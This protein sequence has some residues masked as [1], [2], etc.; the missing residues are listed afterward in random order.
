MKIRAKLISLVLGVVILGVA[1]VGAYI[2]LISPVDRI[3][4]DE[5]HLTALSEAI[6]DQLIELNTLP[7]ARLADGQT[8]CNEHSKIVDEAFTALSKVKDLPKL[9]RDIQSALDVIANLQALNDERLETLRKDFD[10][11]YQD[12]TAVFIFPENKRFSDFYSYSKNP[13]KKALAEA[14]VTHTGK[15]ISDLSILQDSLGASLSTIE[16]QHGLIA[17]A[18]KGIKIVALRTALAIV[19][20]IMILTVAL[21]L[22]F[23]N[24]IAGSII[25]MERNIGKLKEGDISGR[26]VVES[27]DEIGALAGNLNLFLDGLAESLHRIKEISRTNI[28]VKNKLAEEVTEATSST[29]QIDSN[30]K[31]I[32]AQI[33]TLDTRV[34]QSAGSIGKIVESIEG[35]NEQIEGQS[36]MVEEATASVTEMLASLENMSRVTEKDREST[37]ELV[38]VLER[39]RSV[40]DTAFAKVGEIP[41]SIGTI[42]DMAAVIHNIASQ[43]NLLAM[44]AAIEAAHAG[45]AGRGF[46]VVADEI[47][48]LSEL[49]TS[50][51]KDIADSIK[52][53]V[54]KIDEVT[55]ANKGTSQAFS[56]IDVKIREVAKSTSEL[57]ASISEIQT[58]SKQ[59]LQAMVDLQERSTHVKEGSKA[60]D[61]GSTDIRKMTEELT[62]IS[63]EVGSSIAEIVAGV[64]EIGRA[65]R[66]VAEYDD[67]VGE[68]SGRLDSEISRF[69]T[70]A[71]EA[72]TP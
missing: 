24:S 22:V 43:T 14:A 38:Q 39:G 4:A 46:A 28:E 19:L 17:T 33:K 10:V 11:I 42:R 47:R 6:K 2:V 16:E 15:F 23:A 56:A 35:L 61:E 37:D 49:S 29:S 18:L 57:Y 60:M 54:T 67:R 9:N 55:E 70:R 40:F 66:S 59:I 31:S 41:Q 69:K 45:E 53:I 72:I 25:R 7:Y 12:G 32:G 13:E 30:T 65:L 63:T 8:F 5:S 51:S 58:G 36:A 34:A 1:A 71:D 21:S 52:V 20:A 68:G 50:S 44:N 3:Q 62:R 27:R 64:G 26:A 48:K